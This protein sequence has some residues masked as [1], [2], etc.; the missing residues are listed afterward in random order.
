MIFVRD[1][2]PYIYLVLAAEAASSSVNSWGE[3]DLTQTQKVTLYTMAE[4]A[5]IGS[6]VQTFEAFETSIDPDNWQT[7]NR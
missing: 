2:M 5:E 6:R 3:I 7:L 4:P 1:G